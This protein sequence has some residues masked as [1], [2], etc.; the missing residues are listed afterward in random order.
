MRRDEGSVLVLSLSPLVSSAASFRR[1][2]RRRRGQTR[3]VR[4][5]RW[6]PMLVT[7]SSKWI[8]LF[9]EMDEYYE[10]L[11]FLCRFM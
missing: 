8:F 10:F 11:L 3:K 7:V 5:D 6:D 2:A 1:S 9:S 4:D